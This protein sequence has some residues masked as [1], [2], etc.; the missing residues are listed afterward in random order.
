VRSP[1]TLDLRHVG[2]DTHTGRTTVVLDRR[3]ADD[4]GWDELGMTLLSD[5]DGRQALLL[6]APGAPAWQAGRYRVTFVY[7]RD[8]DDEASA[9]ERP[10]AR[11]VQRHLGSDR[12]ERVSVD[13]LV[14]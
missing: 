10:Y 3:R 8:H 11:P 9:A 6:P 2:P 7:H 14:D 1:E 4:L 5:T 12:P 13:W